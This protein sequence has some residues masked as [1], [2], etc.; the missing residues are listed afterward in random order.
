[1]THST[2]IASHIID[3][4]VAL[5]EARGWESIRLH[6]V[7]AALGITLNEVRSHY[8]EKDAVIDAW[9][10]RADRAMLEGAAAPTFLQLAPRE[11]FERA[12]MTW[13]GA[14]QPRRVTREMILSKCEPGHLHI[15]I[16]AVLRISRTVQWMREAAQFQDTFMRRAVAETAHTAIYLATFLC[17]L[18]DASAGAQQTRR[19]LHSLLHGGQGLSRVWGA[20]ASP[21]AQAKGRAAA[22]EVPGG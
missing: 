20:S 12:V 15:Q 13:L 3:T 11:R 17:W 6:E 18:N 19:L 21:V 5:A 14:L 7:A 1:M 4:A 8:R 9:F 2:E 22:T 16:P 10:D